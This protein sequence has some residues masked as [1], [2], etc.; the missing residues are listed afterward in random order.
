VKIIRDSDAQSPSEYG[1]EGLFIVANHRQFYVPEP[2]EK[3]CPEDPDEVVERYKKTHWIF[4][5]EAY[6][7]SGVHLSFGREGNYPDR[8][9]DVSQVGFVFASKKEWRLSKKAREAAK[10]KIDEWNQYLSGDVWGYVVEDERG[11][12]LDSVWGF[13]GIEYCKE[14]AREIAEHYSRKCETIEMETAMAETM[15]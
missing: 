13:Y 7:H 10:S 8:R 11:V 2:G 3:R 14:Q 5:L 4:P 6:I 15:P 9:W 12:S 1:D